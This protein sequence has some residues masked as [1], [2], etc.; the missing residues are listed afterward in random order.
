MNRL[1]PSGDAGA[2]AS[3]KPR[4]RL[5]RK[6]VTLFVSLVSGALLASSA[7]EIYFSYQENKEALVR[8][9]RE[10]A[11]AA[12]A[13]IEQFVKE[14]ERQIGWTTHPQLVTGAAALDQRRVEYFRL[15]RQVPAVTEITQLDAAGREQ[16]RVSRLAMDVVGSQTDFSQDP[17]F[18]EASAGRT[19]F[20]PVRFRKE[21]EPYITV[22][23]ASSGGAPGVTV[24]EVNLK[25][26][27]DV[28][29][30]IKIGK[31]GHAYVV[32][33][34]G[35]LIAHPDISLVLKKSDLSSLPQVQRA[36][37]GLST[38]GEEREVSIARDRE[39]RQ[40]LTAHAGIAPLGWLVFVD[41]PLGE[42]LAP[43][44]SSVL[45]TALLLI[46]GVALSLLASLVLARKMVTPIRA[47]QTGTARIGTGDLSH[48]IEVQTGDELEALADE[49]NQMTTQLQES[50]ANLEQKVEDRTRDLT[51]ALEQQTATSEVLS[52]ISSSPTDAAPIFDAI[53]ER[54]WRLCGA[55]TSAVYRFDG[56]LI[57]LVAQ[58]G[59]A[60]VAFD[61]A[62]QLF[63]ARP[64]RANASTRAILDRVVVH[65]P[66]V[67]EDPEHLH[68]HYARS[69]DVR[70]ILSAPM[71][72]E[73]EPIGT[74][75]VARAEAGP[76]SEKQVALL[77][78]F[79]DQAVIAI[80][81]VRLF[82]ELQARTKELARSVGELEALG[83]VSQAVSSTLDLQT[84][85]TTIVARAVQLS[86]TDGGVIYEY[87]EETQKFGLRAT[88]EMGAELIEVLQAN[89]IR[90]GDGA[91]GQAA[92]IRAPVQVPD[93]LD[94]RE[95]GATRFRPI[96]ARSG[97]R[98]LLAVP[99]LLEQRI[100]G[101]LVVWR[102]E[103]GNFS[104]EIVNLVQT[105][106]TQSMLAIQNARLF[107]E[108][109][110][111]G[112]Q[113]EVANRHKSEF[114]ANMSHELRT[115][116]NAVIGFSE[117]LLERMFGELNDKQA[118][119][120]QDIH[121]SGR[122]L[123]SLINDIL[124]LSKVE[125]GRMELELGAFDLPL[126]LENAL[127][128]VRER[129][130]RHG[131]A[132]DLSVDPQLG[133]IVADERKV[134]QILLNLLSNAVKFT[135]ESGRVSVKAMPAEGAVA[136]SVSDT[137]IG[138]APEDQEAIFEEFRQV[139]S[140][141]TQKREGTGLGLT[142]T[143]KFVELHG[144]KIWVESQLGKG[145]T[146]T[147]TLPLRR[148]AASVEVA[149]AEAPAP[150]PARV[151][152]ADATILLVED[153]Q[154]SVNLLTLYLSGAGFTVAVAHDGQE[155]LDMARRLRPAVILLDIIL[156]RLD[157]W[158]F[159]TQAKADPAIA[160]IPVIVVSMLDEKGKGFTLGA[161]E[162]LV[163]P[164]SRDELLAVLG[165]FSLTTKVR[166]TPVKILAVDDD[167]MALELIEAVLGPEG[168][169]ILKATGGEE[170]LALARR[171]RPALVILDLLMPEVD[172]FAVVE[173]L[174]ADPATAAIPIVILTSK[175]L[176]QED[177]ERL[178]GR[179]SYLARK[180]EFDRKSFVELVRGA[181][182]ARGA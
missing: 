25:F 24:V 90:L 38:S 108:I 106:A 41:L 168:Y 72:R 165:R 174:R 146:F 36:R 81:N 134:K 144:G 143:R 167:P 153:D 85:L 54:A 178:N 93:I 6:Y 35:Q 109:E 7:I 12:A 27:W 26:I 155:G 182:R 4:G 111:K 123:L 46:V 77:K 172:G 13:R 104:A 34:R 44:Y 116:L 73:G 53:A 52:V 125:A 49:F 147:F 14:I 96:L 137:G 160:A 3:R 42:A 163:K 142:L 80:E 28:I 151:E 162:Y 8:I 127:T 113:L 126:A 122:H 150:E 117:V 40:V 156:P 2:A 152:T 5:F 94:E 141:Y 51:E 58:H 78:T 1:S 149:P 67:L 139:G 20:S 157:G 159:L 135:P 95:L 145:S 88:H 128:L 87:D 170:G 136:I 118:E 138:I 71:L 107:R 70:S 61:V 45:R 119:Y 169:T 102:R 9:Q 105:F 47:L 91:L 82:Q 115:P 59:F 92:T 97:Y 121:S 140:D 21:S 171:E 100:M 50:Y 164:V 89:P 83:E 56:E 55:S 75:T 112:R 154:H 15:L 158:D 29:S 131:I 11:L 79:A 64:N 181:C 33:S 177:K 133:E 114:L 39:G 166:E 19:Y 176:T 74:I 175:T 101:G 62:R 180:G 10:K 132:L 120:L 173:R 69:L 68:Q 43:L 130:G 60:P 179:I 18:V 76:F 103:S 148:P 84:V 98:S 66:D 161:A 110:E 57:H 32:D 129:A 65:I 37:A 22:A 23:M 86:G 48:R 16:L 31:A 124:D 30:Q 17:A 99:L 63:P